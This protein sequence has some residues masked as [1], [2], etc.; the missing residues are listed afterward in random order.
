ML[1]MQVSSPRLANSPPGGSTALAF[2]W[3]TVFP[4]P[5]GL[6]LSV[7]SQPA[8]AGQHYFAAMQKQLKQSR[9]RGEHVAGHVYLYVDQ[10][11]LLAFWRL[12]S[13]C[14]HTEWDSILQVFTLVHLKG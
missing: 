13:L 9:L 8:C 3:P 6:L 5:S 10:P 4:V 2:K 11:T 14:I 12:A 1:P 7:N